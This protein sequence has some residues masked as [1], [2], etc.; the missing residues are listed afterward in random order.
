M[1]TQTTTP[2]RTRIINSEGGALLLILSIVALAVAGLF[3]M[4]A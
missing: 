3:A 2:T 1:S 4:G